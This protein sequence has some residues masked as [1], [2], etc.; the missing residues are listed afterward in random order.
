MSRNKK[1]RFRLSRLY[2]AV[3]ALWLAAPAAA[4]AGSQY[5]VIRSEPE[6][7]GFANGQ[8]FVVDEVL[9]IPDGAK[10]TLMDVAGGIVVLYGPQSVVVTEN[11]ADVPAGPTTHEKLRD[12]VVGDKEPAEAIG[13]S[14]LYPTD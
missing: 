8:V 4:I 6:L 1:T 12:L 13:A 11:L 5:M 3:L 14:R 10:V 7:E 2:A 9:T